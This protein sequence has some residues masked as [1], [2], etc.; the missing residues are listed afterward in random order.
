MQGILV[1]YGNTANMD[2]CKYKEITLIYSLS[3]TQDCYKIAANY[4]YSPTFLLK[5]EHQGFECPTCEK[6]PKR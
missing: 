3:I 4:V 2:N 5:L 6:E 1:S